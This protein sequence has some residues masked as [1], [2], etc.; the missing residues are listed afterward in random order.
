MRGVAAPSELNLY[1]YFDPATG[2][3]LIGGHASNP[4]PGKVT[5][6]GV[7]ALRPTG[8]P[9]VECTSTN[10]PAA[11]VQANLM[12]SFG[13]SELVATDA[14]TKPFQFK[15]GRTFRNGI[16]LFYEGTAQGGTVPVSG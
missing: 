3:V 9:L 10:K 15:V 16:A 14:V 6:T 4:K 5:V 13:V 1:D 2:R 11:F 12:C 7:A 8:T